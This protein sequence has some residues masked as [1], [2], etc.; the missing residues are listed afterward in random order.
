LAASRTR[1]KKR[2]S[3]LLESI[4]PQSKRMPDAQ[5]DKFQKSVL[6]HLR[7]SKREAF[8]GPIALQL[9]LATTD[10]AAPQAHTIAKN[11]LDLLSNKRPNVKGKGKKILYQDDSDIH[12]LSVSC[13]HGEKHPSIWITAR[14]FK[15]MLKDLEL[16]TDAM[17]VLEQDDPSRDYESEREYES[18]E[19]F[20]KLLANSEAERAQ[21]GDDLYGAMVKFER[22]NAQRALL[23]RAALDTPQLWWLYAPRDNFGR[24]FG[25]FWN[26]VVSKTPLRIQ[27]GQLPTKPGT[28]SAFV[29]H[30]DQQVQAFKVKWDWLISPLVVPV[31]LEVVIRP[32]PF[33]PKGVLHDLDNVVRDYLIPKIVPTF[34]TVTDHKWMIDFEDLSRRDP[35]LAARWQADGMPPKGTRAGVLRYEA[36]RLPPVEGKAQGFVSVA[37]VASD[38]IIDD[39][40]HKIDGDIER[41]G[42]KVKTDAERR[43]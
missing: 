41:W 28:S 10:H 15:S 6:Q 33:T 32:A 24:S 13:R 2:V 5:R 39:R 42:E 12:A 19:R 3:I 9:D 17:R 40:F 37:I 8:K 22:W 7:D 11:L 31:A 30:V 16:A 1:K 27:I 34:G 21:L 20:K 18:V 23:R 43:Y 25:D 36:W 35:A 29:Q 38:G 26:E 4:E 14:P